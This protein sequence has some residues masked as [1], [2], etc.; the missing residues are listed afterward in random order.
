MHSPRG[1]ITDFDA[2]SIKENDGVHRLQRSVLLVCNLLQ[3]VIGDAA[4]EIG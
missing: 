3:N 2:Q 4:D 1:R